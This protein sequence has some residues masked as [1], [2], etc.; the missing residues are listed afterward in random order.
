MK[1][2]R[3][4]TLIEAVLSLGILSIGLI[5]V[6]YAF[7]GMGTSSLLADQSVIASNI[8]RGALEKV[9]ANRDSDGYWW[10]L[11]NI[12]NGVFDQNPVTNYPPNTYSLTVSAYEV[13]PDKDAG[14]T[15]DF[16]DPMVWSGYARVTS[17]VSWNNGQNTLSLV[18]LIANHW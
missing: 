13:D 7:H 8:S 14:A 17:T 3:G 10:A 6:M 15:D 11:S 12:Q 1:R 4:F 5:G 2:S 16:L 18:T 9:I